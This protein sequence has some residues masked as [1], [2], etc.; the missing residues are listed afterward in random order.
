MMTYWLICTYSLMWLCFLYII[1]CWLTM[2]H[3]QMNF[4]LQFNIIPTSP[5]LH[6]FQPGIILH[7]QWDVENPFSILLMKMESSF[8]ACWT[9]IKSSM[10]CPFSAEHF[11]LPLKHLIVPSTANFSTLLYMFLFIGSSCFCWSRFFPLLTA[12]L[13]ASKSAIPLP[14]AGGCCWP[15]SFL[16]RFYERWSKAQNQ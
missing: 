1:V 2:S 15:F 13:P 14:H 10:R 7:W 8:L 4:I 3:N 6:R 16:L 5:C 11:L 9:Q 12:H